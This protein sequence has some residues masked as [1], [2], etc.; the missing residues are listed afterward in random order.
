MSM[1]FEITVEDVETV[2]RKMRRSTANAEEL[3]DDVISIEVDRIEQ[4]ALEYDDLD[5]QT[6]AAYREMK[7]IIKE[8]DEHN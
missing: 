2:L 1:A 7:L 5:D 4:A 8:N 3:F 6:N